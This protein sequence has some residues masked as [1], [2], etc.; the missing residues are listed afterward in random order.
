MYTFEKLLEKLPF[1]DRFTLNDVPPEGISY[2]GIE[3]TQFVPPNLTTVES[4]PRSEPVQVLIVSAPGAVGK[5]TLARQVAYRKGALLWDLA[6]AHEVGSGSLEGMLT[7]T[8][9]PLQGQD[10]REFLAEGLQFLI[11]DALD[12]GRLK[13]NEQSFGRLL[14]DIATIANSAKGVC[15]VLLGRTDIAERAWVSLDDHGSNAE[16]ISIEAF[17]REQAN[18]Y[19]DYQVPTPKRTSALYEC[20]DL[21]FEK[22]AFS[23]TDGDEADS[24]SE[25]LHYPPVLDVVATLLRDESNLM[26]LKNSLLQSADA[27][28]DSSIQLLLNVIERLLRREQKEKLLPALQLSLNQVATAHNWSDWESLYGSNE[29]CRRLLGS[30]YGEQVTVESLA[31]PTQVRE[32]YERAPEV[33]TIL[34]MHPFLQGTGNFT[35]RVFE[36]YVHAHA[37]LGEYGNRFKDL[38]TATLM[39]P[40]R[41]PTRLLAAFYLTRVGRNSDAGQMAP[42]HLGIVYDSLHSSESSRSLVR[43]TVEGS[44]P[45]S[46]D[47]DGLESVDV[48][49][50][51]LT[52]DADGRARASMSEPIEL[53]VSV[54]EESKIAFTTQLR[55]ARVCV[56]C[57][58][59]LGQ[60]LREFNIGPSVEVN[61]RNIVIRAESIIVNGKA[62][63]HAEDEGLVVLRALD[64]DT[65]ALAVP[66]R[67][68]ERDEFVVAWPGAEHYP[69]NPYTEQEVES[70]FGDNRE[71]E[72]AYRR[73]KR[74]A[75][76]LRSHGRG[77]LARTKV[78]IEHQRVL[79][80]TIGHALL[81]KLTSDGILTLENGGTR[82]FW[83]S[84]VADSMLGVTW[85]HLRNGETPDLLR[86]YLGEFVEQHKSLFSAV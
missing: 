4:A 54:T 73:F 82:Y 20:R 79:K 77:A 61:A 5:S 29:Q 46:D 59:E 41:L 32:A 55:D 53:S 21:I 27:L 78:K 22:L 60:P 62:K 63:R 49:F 19:L 17:S 24:A 52:L 86:Q 11:V 30:I 38:V 16:V 10:Y 56:P 74:I 80:G 3:P 66:P 72:T 25:F 84:D 39:D 34:P 9:T 76:T 1:C 13:V 2:V 69:W 43:M 50:E 75:T 26:D 51:Y 71:L 42:E 18:V 23:V 58:V 44:D 7:R 28:P 31:L 57:V 35:N 33:I 65:T 8:I 40:K 36:A 45:F 14:E 12:E 6:L 70:T 67:V 15:F 37:L 85:Q 47:W 68:F 83:Q 48:E 81:T 64:C